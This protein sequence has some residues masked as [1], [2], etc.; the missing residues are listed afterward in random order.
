[1]AI[2]PAERFRSSMHKVMDV[3]SHPADRAV[4]AVVVEAALPVAVTK[5]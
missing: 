5:H 1:M 4:L 2:R 3:P